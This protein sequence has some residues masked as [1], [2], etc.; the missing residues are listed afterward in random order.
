MPEVVNGSVTP[1]EVY[2]NYMSLWDT[3]DADGVVTFEEFCDYYKD[4][5]AACDS[6][7]AFANLMRSA[8]GL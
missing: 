1:K 8:W 6:D 7:E 3:K 4:V 2:L 5:S